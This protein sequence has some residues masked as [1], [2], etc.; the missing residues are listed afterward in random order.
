MESGKTLGRAAGTV[1]LVSIILGLVNKD[2]PFYD[3]LDKR[4]KD[5]YFII[6]NMLGERDE[7]GFCK[8]FFKF[9]RSREYGIVFGAV[10]DRTLR[11]LK[12]GKWED[13]YEGIPGEIWSNFAPPDITTD[14]IISM[15]SRAALFDSEDQGKTW[16][17]GNIVPDSMADVS[18]E[19]QHDINTS[20]AATA[21]GKATGLSPKKL[22]NIIDS[23]GGYI[24]DL[25]QAATSPKNVGDT[26][27]QTFA[28]ALE[29]M[30]LQ[31][32]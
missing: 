14:N 21:I 29:A 17:G 4:T 27:A 24:G 1:L 16:Y 26:P 20:G 19:N 8:T 15:F 32:L 7:N 2:N 28:N 10:F 22:D 23:Y 30:L 18:P 5:S 11:A 6:P 25:L 12:T 3:D 31:P 13:A 9:P